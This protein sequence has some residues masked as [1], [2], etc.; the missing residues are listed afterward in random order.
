MRV[1]ESIASLTSQRLERMPGRQA[2][3]P[4]TASLTVVIVN[5]CQWKNTTK[6]VKQLRRSHAIKSGAARIVVVDNGSP[7]R[8]GLK[9]LEALHDVNIIRTGENLGFARGVN[10]GCRGLDSDWILLLNPDVTVDDG[11]LDDALST[12]E[13]LLQHQPS[14][15]V[16][17]LKLKHRDGTIQPSCGE[18][19]TLTKTVTGMFTPRWKRKCQITTQDQ[20]RQVPWATGG[21][22]L[23]RR[24][25]FEH[26]HG[27][28]ELY[29]LYY[30]DVDFCRRALAS[31][32]TIWYSPFATATH[33]WPLHS[34]PVP[35]PLRLI[36][37]HALLQYAKRYWPRWQSWMLGRM[38]S[39]ESRFRTWWAKRAGNQTAADF[40]SDIRT[41]VHFHE[42]NQ[43]HKMIEL[44]DKAAEHLVA[45]AAAQDGRTE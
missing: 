10:R 37:R 33:H 14:A 21:C 9:R 6:L 38:I 45:V 11:F 31:D 17:G 18:W 34:R 27:F 20:P 25:C 19:P 30:E 8:I 15:G 2:S 32:F 35:A 28:D 23:I 43:S 36:T 22:L 16:I 1:D 13:Q 12:A 42:N 24:D 41:L 29:F 40:Y 3:I 4:K 5:F 26:L 7:T 44:I 39:L